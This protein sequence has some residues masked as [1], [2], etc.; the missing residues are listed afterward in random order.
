[1]LA[2]VPSSMVFCMCEKLAASVYTAKGRATKVAA[3]TRPFLI[4]L[5]R[6]KAVVAY[7]F[8]MM[9]TAA[10]MFLASMAASSAASDI[11]GST[12]LED[13]FGFCCT[14]MMDPAEPRGKGLVAYS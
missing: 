3:G 7:V 2:A 1:M 10:S 13:L 5:A 11:L 6:T 4:I 9:A 14:N 12:A 8:A